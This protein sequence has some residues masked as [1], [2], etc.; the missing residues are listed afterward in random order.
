MVASGEG[1]CVCHCLFAGGGDGPPPVKK[2]R[3]NAIYV[4]GLALDVTES[5][6][7]EL[8]G[9]IGVIKVCWLPGSVLTVTE[10]CFAVNVLVFL[11]TDRR[12][13]EPMI[14][15][16]KN[17][18][19]MMFKVNDKFPHSCFPTSPSPPLP[20]QGEA[21]ITYDDPHSAKAAIEWFN[22]EHMTK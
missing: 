16:Y 11:Q 3:D 8:F 5:K 21:M 12:T 4:T 18:S 6:L 22:G 1:D 9:S 13:H 15:M 20:P 10:L 7:S 17:K 14:N 2:Q 19:T